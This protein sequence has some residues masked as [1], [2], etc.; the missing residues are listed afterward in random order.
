MFLSKG[1][2]CRPLSRRSSHEKKLLQTAAD[3]SSKIYRTQIDSNQFKLDRLV[4]LVAA[5]RVLN[6]GIH[7]KVIGRC[8]KFEPSLK[9]VK[10]VGLLILALPHIVHRDLNVGSQVEVIEKQNCR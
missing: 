6:I 4:A 5:K 1:Q 7:I 9:S 3:D 2:N 10:H 8:A